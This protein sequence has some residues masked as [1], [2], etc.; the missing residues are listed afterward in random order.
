M[1]IDILNDEQKTAINT[2][3]NILLTACPGSG[4][5][6]VIMYK[7]AYE[8][9]LLE[10]DS[11]KRIIA[12]TFTNRASEEI[13]RRLDL[14]G[15]NS[16]KV[17]TGTLHSFCYEWILKPYSCYL[18]ELAN[19][20]SVADD[21]FCS[22]LLNELKNKH[23]LKLIDSIITRFNRDGSYVELQSTQK[24]ILNEYHSILISKKL[25]DFE[26]ILYYSYKL[27]IDYNN[28]SIVLS[29]LF[30]LICIDEYQD[31]QDLLYA[32]IS[33]IV[34]AGNGNTNV[35]IV[36]DTDQAI[37]T[38][39]GGVPKNLEEIKKEFYGISINQLSLSGN[40]R[41]TQKIVDYF[42][43][44]Q[45]EPIDITAIGKRSSDQGNITLNVEVHYSEI[46]KEISRLIKINLE[47]GIPEDEICVLVPQWWLI[48]GISKKL[49][50]F[51]PL[52][53]FDA[54]GLAPMS[55]NRENI[56]YKL[57]RL[58]LTGPNPNIYNARHRWAD[59]LISDF[60]NQTGIEFEQPTYSSRN[61]LMII[62]SI[63]SK[64]TE[65]LEYLLECFNKFSDKI[66]IDASMY[67]KLV[68]NKNIFV[69]N[70]EDR[71]N[72]KE[73]NIPSDID[74][75]RSFYKERKGVVINTCVGVKG[76][77][78]ETV[79]AYGLLHG[80]I[81]HWND[82]YNGDPINASRKL[83]Y[84]ICSRAKTNLHLIS[85]R[86]RTTK[87]GELLGITKELG[88]INYKYDVI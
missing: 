55:R 21:V 40:Y 8:L 42:S 72:D 37:Y 16:R 41:S 75:M 1:N 17:W 83:L 74:T 25:I 88:K 81:P 71:I 2:K 56:W 66:G 58:F 6:R 10:E 73:F 67:P 9:K 45:T 24:N 28:I 78:F 69:K 29:N 53:N 15:I 50:A 43:N 12:L 22:N 36:G 7:I 18:P 54:S 32:I 87:R 52:V 5:T 3:G 13:V 77:E 35:F 20:Y 38:S 33:R 23:G 84:V 31:T 82:I 79:I 76:E 62:N 34:C 44:F 27:L 46:V 19:G 80:Y 49:R 14:M 61:I 59:E 63:T 57:S 4:K 11:K 70:I 48:T 47:M 60:R 30:K 39:L 65:G 26:M 68:E 51:L 85:E 64:K 86:G